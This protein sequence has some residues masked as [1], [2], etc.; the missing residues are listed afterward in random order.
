MQEITHKNYKNQIKQLLYA[1]CR[2]KKLAQVNYKYLIQ[3]I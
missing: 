1:L 3:A 2:S